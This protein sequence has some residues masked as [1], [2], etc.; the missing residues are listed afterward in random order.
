MLR[1]QLAVRLAAEFPCDLAKFQI[2][3]KLAADAKERIAGINVVA[4]VAVCDEAIV[5]SYGKM[6]NIFTG[7]AN[8]S[9][10]Y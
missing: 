6:G 5:G 7:T 9:L 2:V 3:Q 1:Y 8:R 10:R 4:A